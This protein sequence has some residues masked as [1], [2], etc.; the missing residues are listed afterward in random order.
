MVIKLLRWTMDLILRQPF[1]FWT[2]ILVN[3][4]GVIWGGI[5]WYGPMIVTSP[6]WAFP[7][8]PDCPEA[9]ALW[10]VAALA[11]WAGRRWPTFTALSAFACIKYGFWTL[12]FWTR[13]WTNGAPVQMMEVILFVSHIGLICEGILLLPYIGPLSFGKRLAVIGWFVLS[14]FVDYAL[15]YHPPMTAYVTANYAG[16][17]AIILTTILGIGLLLLP[18]RQSAAA[19][20]RVPEVKPADL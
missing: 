15:G 16:W 6:I 3:L 7:F 1:L 18:Y 11:L 20:L 2:A 10:C 5:F 8:I 14:I 13:H 17:L 4:V 19:P 12:L 9:A